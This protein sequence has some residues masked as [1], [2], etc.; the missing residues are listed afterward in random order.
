V[1]LR[2]AGTTD[3]NAVARQFGGGGHVKASGALLS[4]RLETARP[5]VLAAVRAAL[6]AS[7][8]TAAPGSAE[9]VRDRR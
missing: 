4:E 7:T 1:S 3:V 5:R 9:G 6:L 2:S 8:A